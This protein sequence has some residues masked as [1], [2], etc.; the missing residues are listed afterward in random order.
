MADALSFCQPHEVLQTLY[1]AGQARRAKSTSVRV[2]SVAARVA[3]AVVFTAA[4]VSS[5]PDGSPSASGVEPSASGVE[6][7][8][9]GG[10]PSMPLTMEVVQEGLSIPWDLAFTPDG[11]MLVTER[12]GRLTV[13]ESGEPGA[14]RLA[15]YDIPDALSIGEAGAM[16]IAVDTDFANHPYAYVCVSRDAD[17][18]EGPGPY[19][20]QVLK[21]R[22]GAD[23][24]LTLEGPLFA[25]VMGANRQ[26]N[27][28][29]VEMDSDGL[30]WIS[31]GDNL[32]AK[33]DWPG[34]P[35]RLNGKV[36]RVRRDGTPPD[37]NP[38]FDGQTEP[39]LV[40]SRGHRNPQGIAFTQSGEVFVAEHGPIVND[41]INHIVA[42]GHFGWGCYSGADTPWEKPPPTCEPA[43]AYLP[44]AWAS[45]EVTLATSGATF[46]GEEWGD[47][48]GNLIVATLK[49]NDLRRFVLSPDGTLELEEI[50][51]D[52]AYGR[53]RA[54]VIGSDGALY[55]TTSNASNASKEGKTPVPEQ[56]EDVIVRVAP[57]QGDR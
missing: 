10:D 52:G 3:V 8:A 24:G 51:L 41:E 55:V 4:C 56:H 22:I 20:N 29:A 31:I 14:P 11:A 53:M 45:G 37:D 17:G 54:A 7:S 1:L 34:D 39:S 12:V 13:F 2:G 18:P 28:C 48:N 30:L 49:E 44:P 21:Y 9:A 32:H 16:G 27:G 38:I 26:H 50:L 42:G 33:E 23:L 43:S 40:Y 19:V 15:S 47:W 36:L 35:E 6:P 57:E 46:L 25:Q 5:M